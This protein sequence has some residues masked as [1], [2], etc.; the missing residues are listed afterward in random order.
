M[1]IFV[2]SAKQRSR[3]D[4]VMF[5]TGKQRQERAAMCKRRSV[6]NARLRARSGYRR[7]VFGTLQI[8]T[9]VGI[10]DAIFFE[11]RKGPRIRA[12][13]SPERA[14]P[15]G[16]FRDPKSLP[17]GILHSGPERDPDLTPE[18][19]RAIGGMILRHHPRAPPRIGPTIDQP[20]SMR[21]S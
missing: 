16:A 9:S 6:S 20:W 10:G 17:P 19:C 4:R 7:H 11:T 15:F 14:H 21:K 13:H 3:S 8:S 5:S 2:H 18:S 1:H 12:H